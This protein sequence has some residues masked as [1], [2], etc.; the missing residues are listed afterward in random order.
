[1]IGFGRTEGLEPML[2]ATQNANTKPTAISFLNMP[3]PFGRRNV[4]NYAISVLVW[5][6]SE[7]EIGSN[8]R[9]FRIL[10]VF[11]ISVG[12]FGVIKKLTANKTARIISTELAAK[13]I[14]ARRPCR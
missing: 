10:I 11:Q 14:G 7:R 5:R 12:I 6:C 8:A 4:K 9:R 13:T 3:P 2:R 1:M